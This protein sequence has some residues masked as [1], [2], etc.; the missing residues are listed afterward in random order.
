MSARHALE[1][2]RVELVS[3]DD[4]HTTL[5]FGDQGTVALVDDLGT[6]FVDWDNGSKLGLVPGHDSYRVLP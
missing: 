3:T 2:R 1:G 6:L 4:P 5:R